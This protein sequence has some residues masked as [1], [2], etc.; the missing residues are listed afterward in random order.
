MSKKLLSLFL[1]V[2]ML[3]LAIPAAILPTFAAEE[4]PKAAPAKVA[5]PEDDIDAPVAAANKAPAKPAD[6]SDIDE[7]FSIFKR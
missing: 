2:V 5:E 1:A 4:T 6:I 7:I 3:A